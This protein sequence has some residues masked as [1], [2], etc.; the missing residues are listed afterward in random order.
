MAQMALIFYNEADEDA[1]WTKP[2]SDTNCTDS[3]GF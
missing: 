3:H 2:L 1:E